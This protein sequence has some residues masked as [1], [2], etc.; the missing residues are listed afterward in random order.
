[1][2]KILSSWF[3]RQQIK[4]TSCLPFSAAFIKT[5]INSPAGLEQY[6]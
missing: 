1:M 5:S 6:F 3:G 4:L 2:K